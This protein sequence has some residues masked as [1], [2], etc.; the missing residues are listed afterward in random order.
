MSGIDE[1]DASSEEEP[2]A[3]SASSADPALSGDE[4]AEVES[5]P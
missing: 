3:G 5:E 4:A 2:A 1:P